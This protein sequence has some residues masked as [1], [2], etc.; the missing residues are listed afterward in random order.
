MTKTKKWSTL[1]D[2]LDDEPGVS[3]QLEEAQRH[4]DAERREYTLGELRRSLGVTQARLAELIGRSQSAVSQMESGH[5][6]ISVNVLRGLIEQLGGELRLV[7]DMP[8]G[9]VEIDL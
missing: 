3:E 1:R 9:S 8:T 7:A 6:E 5:F 2:A 4:F